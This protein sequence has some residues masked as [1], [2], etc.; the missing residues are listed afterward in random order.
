MKTDRTGTYFYGDE[1]HRTE[2][3]AMAKAKSMR[4]EFLE[5]LNFETKGD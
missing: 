1:W 4:S 5:K 2:A 3:E